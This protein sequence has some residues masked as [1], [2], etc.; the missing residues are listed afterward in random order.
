MNERAC[1]LACEDA[2]Y[3]M[4]RVFAGITG[5]ALFCIFLGR[6]WRK[7]QRVLV[8]NIRIVYRVTLCCHG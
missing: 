6:F 5:V 2:E 4:F 8:I 3:S 1:G 7:L